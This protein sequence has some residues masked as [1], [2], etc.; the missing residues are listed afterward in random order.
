LANQAIDFPLPAD[1]ATDFY[2]W[3]RLHCP[4]VLAPLE[5]QLLVQSTGTGFSRAMGE[6][7]SGIIAQCHLINYYAYLKGVPR[8]LDA[9]D[10]NEARNERYKKNAAA[11]KPALGD[12]WN[13][14]WLPG[15]QAD[16]V[17]ARNVDYSS[18]S[19]A[20][21]MK[22][23]DEMREGVI[24]RWTIHG[25][26]LY[27]F[28][29]ANDFSDFYKE[30]VSDA[31]EGYEAL[32]GFETE[33][34]KSSRGLW[35]LSRTVR[36]N[37]ELRALFEKSQPS[38]L[39]AELGKSPAGKAFLADLDAYLKDYGWRSDS[40]YE[41]TQPAWWEDR[42]IPLGAIQGYVGIGDE[43]SPDKQLAA[44]VKRRE[45][46][47]AQARSKLANDAAKLKQFNDLYAAAEAFTQIVEDH[48]H[49]ID[50][51]GDIT[52]RYPALEIGKRL[53]AKGSLAKA[54]DVFMLY[55][56][57]LHEAMSGGKDLKA[58]VKQRKDD[59][60]RFARIVPPPVMGPPPP[61]SD[62]PVMEVLTRFFG[63][64]VEP[65]TDASILAGIAAA[66]GTATGIA[67]VVKSLD[68]ASKLQK[69]DIMVCEMT[70][71]PWTPLFSTVA[72]VVA[73]TGGILSHCAIVAREYLIPCV[74]G[75]GV[76]T[77]TIKDGQTVTVDGSK[78]IVRIES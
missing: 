33:A 12:K 51:M 46:L 40:V 5:H 66:P 10:T 9:G 42:G 76:G 58:L 60:A 26:L 63:T 37:P 25:M 16:L 35:Q 73:D 3:D 8:P 6:M 15:M 61:D 67:K 49:W 74:V 64:P 59:Q 70:L 38:Q 13:K 2:L 36:S 29:A 52:M 53:T 50:Q 55:V 56:E 65:S 72:A 20:N 62:D 43:A 68:E 71:P 14:E 1:A 47:L 57:E 69:G 31:M 21:L 39:P 18:Y 7:G 54:E 30:H 32:Q 28:A 22:R 44:A 17:R 23:F 11:L 34:T 19:D 75:T 77:V 48:N 4:R 78:G 45:E 24:D 27:G 41:L